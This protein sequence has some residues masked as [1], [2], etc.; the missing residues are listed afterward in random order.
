[1]DRKVSQLF[2]EIVIYTQ[3]M[4]KKIHGI[5]TKGAKLATRHPETI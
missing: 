3:V 1:M 2:V 5:W 4:Y